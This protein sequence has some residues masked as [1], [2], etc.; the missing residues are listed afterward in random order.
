MKI[1]V[2]TRYAETD[3]NW[4]DAIGQEKFIQLTQGIKTE[5]ELADWYASLSAY[6]FPSSGEGWSFTPRESL[7]LGIPTILSDIPVHQEL[8]AT[9]YCQVIPTSGREPGIYKEYQHNQLVNADC[10]YWSRIS[11]QAIADAIYRVYQNYPD[12]QRQAQ[13]G[14]N[15]IR[16]QWTNESSLTTVKHI[17]EQL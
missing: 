14:Q 12:W 6:C 10:G 4:L 11:N 3:Q 15:W 7:Y 9:G 5:R 16:H 8:V 2:P 17:I 13:L 1:H